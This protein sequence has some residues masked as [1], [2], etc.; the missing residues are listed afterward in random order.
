MLNRLTL[1]LILGTLTL[2][3]ASCGEFSAPPK[4]ADEPAKAAAP[5]PP[6][7]D[8]PYYELTK[9][10]ITSHPDWSSR[11]IMVMGTKLGE[12]TT[13]VAVK[14]F[15]EQMGKTNVLAEEYQTYYQ[16]NGIALFTFKL[17]GKLRRIEVL[18]GFADRIADP[19]L[20]SLVANGDLKQMRA[21]F[22]MEESME[23]K[24]D[25]MGTEYVYDT[26]GIRFIKYKSG[27][28]GLRF[29]DLKK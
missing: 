25:E 8:G 20:K 9:D 12:K 5:K 11:N 10:E 1:F 29:S 24:P 13:D 23:D 2:G 26:K 17:T 16:K 19:K 6:E 7:P 22:G 28:I 3:L 14:N 15:G 4:E 27:N 21:I 18:Q